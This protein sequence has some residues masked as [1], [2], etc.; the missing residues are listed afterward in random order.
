VLFERDPRSS[1]LAVSVA[2]WVS[3][4]VRRVPHWCRQVMDA[5][6]AR[7]VAALP[8]SSLDAIE[9]SGNAHGQ[10]GWRSYSTLA[11]PSFDL[12]RPAEPLPQADVVF[13]EQVLEH[14]REPWRAARTL[15]DLLRPGGKLVISTP[16]LIRIHPEPT[17]YW[18]FTPDGLRALLEQANFQV[19][20]VSQ[21]GNLSSLLAN[22]FFWFP[23]VPGL[24]S[25]ANRKRLPLVVWAVAERTREERPL[26]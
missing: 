9:V 8:R 16:F 11:F 13:C 12:C 3:R 19:S 6:I 23:Y 18:R 10:A 17:D 7:Y 2:E 24:C 5:D 26:A 14:V 1:G 21:W 25:L 4:T 22:T 20:E 15:H